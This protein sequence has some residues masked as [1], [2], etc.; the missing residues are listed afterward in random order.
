MKLLPLAP[1]CLLLA[2][3]SPRYM[4][5]FAEPQGA[6]MT[7]QAPVSRVAA[8]AAHPGPVTPTESPTVYSADVASPVPTRPGK[9]RGVD[10]KPVIQKADPITIPIAIGA[11]TPPADW[12]LDGNLQRAI[13]FAA[14]GVV[15][16]LIGGNFFVVTGSL[17][18]LL[19]LIF[20]IKW[21]IR[22]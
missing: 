15:A 20:G 12:R 1:L 21:F 8:P 6:T 11:K 3:S 10:E 14:F 18:L 17:S 16:L 13:I 22:R 2:C 7:R 4:Y 19:G 9:I 5:R